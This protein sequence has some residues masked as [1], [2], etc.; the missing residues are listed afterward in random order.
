MPAKKACPTKIFDIPVSLRLMGSKAKLE[1]STKAAA[2]VEIPQMNFKYT[3][4]EFSSGHMPCIPC[5]T[6]L[7]LAPSCPGCGIKKSLFINQICN[8]GM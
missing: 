1:S 8:V 7:T 5:L 6:C 3:S 2:A 4:R